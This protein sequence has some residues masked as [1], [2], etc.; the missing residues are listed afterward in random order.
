MSNNTGREKTFVTVLQNGTIYR[1]YCEDIRRLF[2]N[3]RK[4]T[5]KLPKF[6]DD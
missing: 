1:I 6:Y 2:K 5:P 3:V 4:R